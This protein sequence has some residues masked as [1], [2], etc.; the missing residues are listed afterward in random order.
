MALEDVYSILG[1]SE[2][3]PEQS[4]EERKAEYDAKL[5]AAIARERADKESPKSKGRGG[6]GRGQGRKPGTGP[7]TVAKRIP[8]HL[9]EKIDKIDSLLALLD[10]WKAQAQDAPATSPRWERCRQMLRDIDKLM[11]D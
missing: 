1:I 11:A 5:Q 7:K 10:D 9:A 4:W 3:L 2:L 6:A 8:E